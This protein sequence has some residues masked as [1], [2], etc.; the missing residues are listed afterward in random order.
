MMWCKMGER[1]QTLV[2]SYI[3]GRRCAPDVL[4]LFQT[5]LLTVFRRYDIPQIEHKPI[6]VTTI[7][8]GVQTL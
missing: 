1:A 8:S 2:R 5:M 3:T 4:I 7:N 6:L